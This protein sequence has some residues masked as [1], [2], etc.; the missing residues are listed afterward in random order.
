M[1]LPGGGFVVSNSVFVVWLE[2]VAP[3]QF[4]QMPELML[5]AEQGVDVCLAPL[6]LSEARQCYYQFLTGMGAGKL[7]RFDAVRP[8]HYVAREEL[9]MP[10][11]AYGRLLLDVIHNAHL[12]MVSIEIERVEE[13]EQL[14]GSSHDFV[15]VCV[16][17]AQTLASAM[18]EALVQRLRSFTAATGHLIVVTDVWNP[19]VHTYVNVNDF[20]V[21]IGLLEVD[22][23][24]QPATIR[25]PETLAYGLG[26]GQLWINLRGRE[27]QGVVNAGREYQ[28]VCEA[29]SRELQE[30][31][32]DPRTHEPVVSQVFTRDALYSGDYLFRAPD[33]TLV[34]HPGY[35]PSPNAV[36]LALDGKSIMPTTTPV[37]AQS[38]APYARLLAIGPVFERGKRANARLV[39]VLPTLMY[40]LGRPVPYGIDGEV[41]LS[42]FTASYRQQQRVEIAEDERD[43]LSE[44]EE[45]MIVERLRDLG[46][47]G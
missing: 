38:E 44:E 6:P 28:E 42:L 30:N 33:L 35:A 37:E 22:A 12:S 26:T 9:E 32:L 18:L 39:D 10:E 29:L 41:L 40:L 7:G 19:P 34:Y 21:E 23:S 2:G 3:A 24:S 8:D 47:L 16:R 31:W 5:L 36:M 45:G 25:W 20:L 13:L 11:G 17:N 1:S 27:A 46:Y 43:M 15:L 14:A 4:E